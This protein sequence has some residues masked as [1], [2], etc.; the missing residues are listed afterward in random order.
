MSLFIL[1][2]IPLEYLSI[3][4][5]PPESYIR[6][7]LF[8]FHVILVLRGWGSYVFIYYHICRRLADFV[9]NSA[10]ISFAVVLFG[11][12]VILL[13]FFS[14]P[15]YGP[16]AFSCVRPDLDVRLRAVVRLFV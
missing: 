16:L 10:I 4:P 12:S 13:L 15:T 6:V 8:V 3:H 9:F 1:C 14:G 11:G 2:S 5:P 7:L